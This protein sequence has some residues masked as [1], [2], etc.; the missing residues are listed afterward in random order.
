M[1]V[2]KNASGA[3]MAAAASLSFA[4]AAMAAKVLYADGASPAFFV[5]VRTAMTVLTIGAF[6]LISSGGG[7]MLARGAG[8]HAAVYAAGLTAIAYGYMGALA[9]IPAAQA[10]LLFYLYPIATVLIAPAAEGRAPSALNTAAAAAAFAGLFFVLDGGADALD[11]RGAALGF[12]A[13]AG[14]CAVMLSAPGLIRAAG[15][16]AGAFT[17]TLLAFPVITAAG[18]AFA[19]ITPPAA[20][21][22]LWLTAAAGALFGGAIIFLLLAVRSAG[23]ARASVLL[24]AEPVFVV[25]LAMLLFGE[26]LSPGQWAGA[27]LVMGAVMSVALSPR[28]QGGA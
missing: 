20:S 15:P 14:G 28:R 6:Q 27:A 11:W 26:H 2:F 1:S 12:L 7:P 9:Y 16:G 17:G 21:S 10:V 5:I 19:E 8:T 24:N 22:G 13:A 3:V 23:P 25:V 18:F 4:L